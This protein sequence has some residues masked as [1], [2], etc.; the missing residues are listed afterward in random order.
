MDFGVYVHMPFCRVQCPYCT[1]YTVLRP[2]E[3]TLPRRL[4]RAFEREWDLR[5][6]PRLHRGDRVAT[7]YCGGGTP[8]DL[9]P[10]A[11]FGFLDRV[12]RD[13]PDGLAGLAETT[14]E[15]NP[16]SASPA[17]LDGLQERGIG[18]VSLGIQ[19]LDDDDLRVLGRAASV[20][21]NRAALAAVGARFAT[22]NADLI[23]GIPGS[24]R[25]RLAAALEELVQ[26][27][28]PHLSLY[29]LELPPGRARQFGDP[30]TDAS[31]GRKAADYGWASAWLEARGFQHYEISNLARS[32]HASIHN[33]A[34]WRGGEYVGLGPGAHSH[35][36]GQRGANRADLPAYLEALEAGQT[37]PAW[38][39]TLTPAM[40]RRERVLLGLR[41]REG[42]ERDAVAA[43]A[44]S[45]LLER[46]QS[47][48]YLRFHEDRIQLTPKGWLVSDSIVLQL[49][50]DE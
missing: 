6:A 39:E 8:S 18:R 46:L 3:D 45:G 38:R 48:G 34:T 1:F 4:A 25:R 14:V 2:A 31:E 23:L 43:S 49:V 35:E 33:S 26:A 50:A 47:A 15:C 41:L 17:L 12:D 16:E 30:Q 21:E 42:L 36:Q 5:V 28:A 37:P 24:N 10:D 7:L 13:L 32:G 29:C 11:L 27:G 9:P 44:A 40:L 20:V 22:W 19:A